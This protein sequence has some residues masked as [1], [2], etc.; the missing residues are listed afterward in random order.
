[1]ALAYAAM[2]HQFRQE[3]AE[4]RSRA[5]AALAICS[6]H[7]FSY[8]RA[9]AE[10]LAGW[11]DAEQGRLDEGIARATCGLRDLRGTGAELRL[12]FYLGLLADL[13]HRAGRAEEA[14]G[15]LSEAMAVAQCNDESWNDPNLHMLKGRLLGAAT[16]GEDAGE[17]ACLQ[18]AIAIAQAQDAMSLV[19]RATV[20]LARLQAE[21]GR[22]AEAHDLL[23]SVY[24]GFTEGLDTP[25]LVSA[26]TVLQALSQKPRSASSRSSRTGRSA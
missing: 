22:R 6:E 20:S 2:L 25:D 17:E 23:A 26:R 15:A 4:V 18:Q 3:P 19:L 14:A 16:P 24:G 1:M 11:A 9:W 8:Y 10:I 13:S 12:P 7:G 21:Q 5:H